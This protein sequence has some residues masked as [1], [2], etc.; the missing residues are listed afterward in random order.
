MYLS[1]ILPYTDDAYDSSV[2]AVG[3]V[4]RIELEMTVITGTLLL[5]FRQDIRAHHNCIV[6]DGA[7]KDG[8][9][10]FDGEIHMMISQDSPYNYF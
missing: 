5:F 6:I 4:R 3:I 7:F 9:Y 10:E 2:T 8:S 1:R